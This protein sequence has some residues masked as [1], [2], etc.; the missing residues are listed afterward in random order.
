MSAG[1]GDSHDFVLRNFLPY[2]LNQAAESVSLS[3]Q[4]HYRREGLSRTQWRVMAHLHAESGLTAKEIC[5]RSHEEKVGVSRAVAAL[6]RRGLLLRTPSD[7][8]R[9]SERLTLTAAG[10]QLF[11]RLADRAA[12]FEAELAAR[13][14]EDTLRRSRAMLE[15]LLPKL[16]RQTPKD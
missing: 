3:F 13:I 12:A 15:E 9:R 7:L 1:N 5:R 8:D 11:A 4:E 10:Q 16:A 6:E 2:M 14:G